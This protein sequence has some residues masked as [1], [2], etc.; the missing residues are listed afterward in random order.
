MNDY[1]INNLKYKEAIKIDKR[2]ILN[3]YI[4]LLKRKHIILFSFIP[5]IDYNLVSIKISLFWLSFSTFFAIN[6][7]FFND[8]TMHTIYK[9]EINYNFISHVSIITCSSIISFAINI[10][11]KQFI[12]DLNYRY[13]HYFTGSASFTISS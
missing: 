13:I 10:L 7:F 3:Y 8:D 4:S 9:E 2:S 6:G 1:E 5:M 11:F 12:S